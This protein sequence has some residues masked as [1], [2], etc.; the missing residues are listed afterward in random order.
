MTFPASA[1]S[2]SR[3]ETAPVSVAGENGWH[4]GAEDCGGRAK[5]ELSVIE[6]RDIAADVSAVGEDQR[7]HEILDSGQF[8]SFDNGEIATGPAELRPAVKPS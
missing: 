4:D 3:P 5:R 2:P 8:D 7:D 6:E 1:G